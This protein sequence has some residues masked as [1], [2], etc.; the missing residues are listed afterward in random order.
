MISPMINIADTNQKRFNQHVAPILD[1]LKELD[2]MFWLD[3]GTLLGAVRDRVVND[4]DHDFDISVLDSDRE[5]LILAKNLLEDKGYKVVLQKDMHW[6]EDLMQIYIPRDGFITDSKGRI[7]EGFDHV[8]IYIYTLIK[9]SFCMRRIHEPISSNFL[10]I[11]FYRLYRMINK[12]DLK[13][14]DSRVSSKNKPIMFL[15]S[16]FITLPKVTREVLSNFIWK[17]YLKTAKSSWLISPSK[18][19][20][21]FTSITLYGYELKIPQKYAKYLEYRYSEKWRIPDKNWDVKNNGGCVQKKIKSS[22][23]THISVQIISN[24]NKYLWK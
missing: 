13:Y 9:D 8:D 1:I 11:N 17:L 22:K 24:F 18:F 5:K 10:G 23:F 21:E 19:F 20:S 12:S 7:I 3:F 16:N 6:F 14:S 15:L 2:V 4:W